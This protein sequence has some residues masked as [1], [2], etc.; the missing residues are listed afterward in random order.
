MKPEASW[1]VIAKIIPYKDAESCKF[2]WMS[3]KKTNL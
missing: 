3:M 1:D 2:K